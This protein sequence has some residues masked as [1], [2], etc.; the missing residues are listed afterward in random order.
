VLSTIKV[1]GGVY[2]AGGFDKAALEYG[3]PG[4]PPVANRYVIIRYDSKDGYEKARATGIKKF[5]GE[6]EK[7]GTTFRQVGVEGVEAK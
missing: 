2:L 7:T 3:S 5:V 6:Q 4:V 1:A